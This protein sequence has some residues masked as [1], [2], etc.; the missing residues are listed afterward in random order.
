MSFVVPS[1]VLEQT[2]GYAPPNTVPVKLSSMDE[3]EPSWVVPTSVNFVVASEDV[4]VNTTVQV[5]QSMW[6]VDGS[7]ILVINAFLS[8][9][10]GD[11]IPPNT[12]YTTVAYVNFN[13]SM[14][15]AYTSS[16]EIVS[17]PAQPVIAGTTGLD[18]T[19]MVQLDLETQDPSLVTSYTLVVSYID[20]GND[21]VVAVIEGVMADAS[22]MM[23][24]GP[25]T[26]PAYTFDNDVLYTG[27]LMA[28]GPYGTSPVSNEFVINATNIPS[29]VQ[30]L[31]ALH[32]MSGLVNPLVVGS[33]EFVL[34]WDAPSNAQ[35]VDVEGYDIYL[36]DISGNL[37]VHGSVSGYL[38]IG[39]VPPSMLMFNTFGSSFSFVPGE[40]YVFAVV[41]TGID[42]D[43]PYEEA[44]CSGVAFSRASA[45][46]NVVAVPGDRR[47]TLSWLP[48]AQFDGLEMDE[49]AGYKIVITNSEDL[50]DQETYEVESSESSL[51]I[52]GLLNDVSYILRIVGQF[53]IPVNTDTSDTLLP[54]V[55]AEVA[56]TPTVDEPD[57]VIDFNVI[58]TGDQRVA[59]GWSYDSVDAGTYDN[60]FEFLVTY[61][62]D[63]GSGSFVVEG[64][65]GDEVSYS[66]TFTGLVNETPY[67]FTITVYSYGD[68]SGTPE[69]T[70]STASTSATPD[71]TPP[72]A[73]LDFQLEG[74]GDESLAV[75]WSYDSEDA[76]DYSGNFIF[77]LTYYGD[78]LSGYVDIPGESGVASY[79][80]ELSG[81]GLENGVEY[82]LVLVVIGQGG[83]TPDVMSAPATLVGTPAGP[84][85]IESLAVVSGIMTAVVNGN[86]SLL[87]NYTIV[88]VAETCHAGP[89]PIVYPVFT[90]PMAP[91]PDSGY[92]YT[93]TYEGGDGEAPDEVILIVSNAVAQ[94]S[95]ATFSASTELTMCDNT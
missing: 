58:D 75:S 20:E 18:E 61:D 36:K 15:S 52:Y 22:G 2:L 45:P 84:P 95:Q 71:V 39:S 55:P 79:E 12:S 88:G 40:H 8:L 94:A 38:L 48:P 23:L 24:V 57:A 21:L 91:V 50:S 86:G 76:G 10:D 73:V 37:E 54:S 41:A 83:V 49:A 56:S 89:Y 43:S 70:S 16:V 65:S 64:V 1:F 81:V 28:V 42:G 85:I 72:D 82:T 62:S 17:G 30:N 26:T 63:D 4:I 90:S 66:H 31:V 87:Q 9:L 33:P 74:E 6:Y 29:A 34:S 53:D 5:V 32:S 78:D 93:I 92:M 19:V 80:H 13:N 44:D 77:R 14:Q 11:V 67:T 47:V 68:A 25:S 69:L 60:D 59:L 3:Y 46:Q 7:G 51:T 27:V 35:Y